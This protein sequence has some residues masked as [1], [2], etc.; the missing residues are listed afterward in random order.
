MATYG[1]DRA[2]DIIN[3]DSMYDDGNGIYRTGGGIR[4]ALWIDLGE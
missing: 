1:L 4:P 3:G 2:A